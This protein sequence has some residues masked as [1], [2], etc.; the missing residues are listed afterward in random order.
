MDTTK[1]ALFFL[2]FICFS[3]FLNAQRHMEPLSRGGIA[4][5]KN[6][7]SV[8]VNWRILGNEFDNGTNYN[9]YRDNEIIATNLWVSNYTDNTTTNGKYQIV[10][11]VNGIE[12]DRSPE[13]DV[14]ANFYFEIPLKQDAGD[15]YVHLAWVGDLDGDGDFEFVVDRIPNIDGL[16]SK[17]EAYKKDGT[18]LWQ[19]DMGPLSLDRDGI[20]GGAAAISNGM[21]DGVTV[22]DLD[23]D[24]KSEVIIKSANGTRF[25]DGN[26]LT[27]T[28]NTQNFVSV[29]NG[30]TGAELARASLPADYFSDGPLQTQFNIAYLDGIMPSVVI[31]AKNRIGS[32]DFNEVIAAYNYSNNQIEQQWKWLRGSQNC[33]D[34]HQQRIADVDNDGKD[35][36]IDG[37]FVIDDNGT[38]LYSLGDQGIVHGDRFHIGDF[39]PDHEGLEGYGIQQDNPSGLAWY[40]YSAK[41][42]TI[43]QAQ[44]LS[45]IGDY[46]RGNVADLDPNHLG[47]EMWTFTDGIYNVSDG[48]IT[49]VIP[50]SYPNLRLWWDGD[51]SSEMLD[52]VKFNKWDNKNNIETRQLT[53]SDYGAVVTWRNVPV[54][55]GDIIGDWREEVVYEKTDH[56]AL[57]I[58]STTEPSNERIYTPLHNPEYRLCLTTKGYYQS[59][60]IDY[61]LGSDM[62]TPPLPPMQKAKAIWTGNESNQWNTTAGNWKTSNYA[63]IY[64]E[65]DSVMFD[66]SGSKNT[67]IEINETISPA[68]IYMI[69]PMDYSLS[70]E[71]QIS[72]TGGLIKSGYGK[73]F[74]D[75]NTSY[76]AETKVEQGALFVNAHLL[77]SNVLVFG[78]AT[79]GGSGIIGETCSFEKRSKLMPGKLNELGTITFQKALVL[80]DGLT[81]YFDI[82]S[83]STH[84]DSICDKIVVNSDITIEKNVV[85]SFIDHQP[86]GAGTYPLISYSGKFTG[87]LAQVSI[88]NLFGS[89]YA[90]KDSLNTIW[91]HIYP[92]RSS[93]FITWDGS[94]PNWDLQNSQSWLNQNYKSE[95]VSGDTVVF[96]QAGMAYPTVN[97]IGELPVG[98]MI[99]NT[100]DVNYSFT[101]NGVIGG[102]G[103]LI[104]NGGGT[105]SMMTD[106]NT[107]T[108]KTI[109]NGGTFI[110]NKLAMAG[111]PSSIGAN[112]STT[113]NQF[114]LN[115]ARFDLQSSSDNYTDKGLTL[116]GTS[117]TIHIGKGST[118][119][120]ISGQL[121]GTANLVK[122]GNGT[123]YLFENNNNYTGGTIIQEGTI[124]LNDPGSSLNIGSLG[125][126]TVTFKGGALALGDTRDYTSCNINFEVPANHNGTIYLDQ[127]CTYTG[128]LKGSGWLNIVLPGSIDR[129]I[130]KGN[131]S[132]FNGT[133]KVSGVG[134][135]RLASSS[136]YEHSHFHLADGISMYYSEGTSSGDAVAQTVNIGGL[137]GEITSTLAGENWIIGAANDTSIFNGIITGNSLTKVGN[138]LLELTNASSY[139]GATNINAGTLLVSNTKGSATGSGKVTVNINGKL[140]GE[141]SIAGETSVENGG[142]LVPG[143]NNTGNKLVIQNDI[144]LKSGSRLE[145]KANPLFKL[146]DQLVVT[147]KITIAGNLFITNTTTSSYSIGDEFKLFDASDIEGAF[148]SITPEIPGENMEWDLSDLNSAGL[149]KVVAR[150]S[151]K[152]WYMSTIQLYPNPANKMIYI[153]FDASFTGI[154]KLDICDVNGR[155]RICEKL[156]GN[157]RQKINIDFLPQ[158]LYSVRIEQEGKWQIIKLLKY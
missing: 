63:N 27:H 111:Q 47:Y 8:F 5:R 31:K 101:G 95:F 65:G 116:N 114:V 128:S 10:A 44:Y 22:F 94:S 43:L 120:S 78:G 113:P 52:G 21:W 112:V 151:N 4:I 68:L 13:I 122:T 146:I 17:V 140:T 60:Q 118:T 125:N 74:L 51:L 153:D 12:F 154:T 142:V 49:D 108:G 46:A 37:G 29:L 25:G 75:L 48:K 90:L 102:D 134:P 3:L 56:S 19:V 26:T 110:A 104:K 11:V 148:T 138:G 97:L 144:N 158:G 139:S 150:T 79:L 86:V 54:L 62:T 135:M 14:N 59:T 55:Y 41:D 34:Y 76:S 83:Q 126:G 57:I 149:I 91:L 129:T 24:G 115:N 50:A 23:T 99:V 20:E 2:P 127:R 69:A 117:D 121:T 141:G 67:N 82:K 89:K 137:S 136:G 71:G 130:F 39:D 156:E 88:N 105:L 84:A 77:N 72:G 106:V 7:S 9:L 93:S 40:S 155:V 133:V 66:L 38:L 15:C 85:F 58:F 64:A 70:G 73:L 87:N 32:G 132:A 98:K 119:L 18:R 107:Y 33:P 42:G 109:I 143:N 81:C 45:S 61:Y 103:D 123:L 131:W 16:S 152:G 157:T 80:S 36:I 6:D 96:D 92:S 30:E 1:R 53:A 124:Q 145:V 35:E 147:G 28:N 100:D